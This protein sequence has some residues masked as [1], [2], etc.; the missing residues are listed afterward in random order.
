MERHNQRILVRTPSVGVMPD[1]RGVSLE[2]AW[3]TRR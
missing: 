2:L 3:F 1:L